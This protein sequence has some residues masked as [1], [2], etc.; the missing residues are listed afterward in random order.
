[1]TLE[2]PDQPYLPIF[3]LT[4]GGIVETI[5]YGAIAVVD[6]RGR[7]VASYGNPSTVTY[8]RS[9]AKP[10]QVLSFIEN[11]GQEYFNLT[12]REIALTCASHSGTDDHVAVLL[13]IQQKASISESDLLCGTHPPLHKPTEQALRER[14]EKP[15]PN[16]HNCS[17]K[18]TSM[19]AYARM[20]G[21]PMQDYINPQHPVQQKIIQTFSEMSGLPVEKIAIGIDGCSAPNFAV[22]LYNA[23]LAIARLCDPENTEPTLSQQRTAAC[24]KIVQAMTTNPDMVGGPNSFDTHLMTAT[25]GQILS[26]GGAEGYQVLGLMPGV[27]ATSSP[28]LGIAYKISDGDLKSHTR[29]VSDP[30]GQARP[31]VAVEILSQLGALSPLMLDS[32]SEYGPTFPLY[33]WR[34]LLVGEAHPCFQLEF[35]KQSAITD[36]TKPSD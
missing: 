33:N 7:L 30:R 22:P 31:A 15:T 5:H 28:G 16:R 17:G 3:E 12:P 8:L 19:L 11:R 24:R 13:G 26:K 2:M 34:K 32:L 1:M 29:P 9:S 6:A 21:E 14:G 18:H 36:S 25:Q 20:L 35:I 23:A 10:I 27:L 4:R